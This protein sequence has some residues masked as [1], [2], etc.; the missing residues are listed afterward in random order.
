MSQA[1][2]VVFTDSYNTLETQG[3]LFAFLDSRNL[4]GKGMFSV[5]LT[6]FHIFP[7]YQPAI[8]FENKLQAEQTVIEGEAEGFTCQVLPCSP[9]EYK[10]LL[11]SLHGWDSLL[12]RDLRQRGVEVMDHIYFHSPEHTRKMAQLFSWDATSVVRYALLLITEDRSEEAL[13]A[14]R[15]ALNAADSY[16]LQTRRPGCKD[17]DR[18]AIRIIMR[19][20]LRGEN[21]RS[22]E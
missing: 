21:S 7:N 11:A 5:F 12:K 18:H 15:Q 4:V 1:Y 9:G 17:A 14:C 3:H 22:V 20:L 8:P 2:K 16:E 6:R 19:H 13:S 10:Q